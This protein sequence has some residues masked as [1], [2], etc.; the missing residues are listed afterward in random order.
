MGQDRVQIWM[1][2]GKRLQGTRKC[3][4]VRQFNFGEL[5]NG[6]FFRGQR[7]ANGD[8]L[9]KQVKIDRAAEDK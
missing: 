2:L 6:R 8:D 7:F 1:R 3:F 9:A 5:V 4:D